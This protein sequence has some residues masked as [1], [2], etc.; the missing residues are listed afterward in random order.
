M[1]KKEDVRVCPRCKGKGHIKKSPYKKGANYEYKVKSKLELKGYKVYRSYASKGTFDLIATKKDKIIGVQVKRLTSKNPSY[2]T[3][4]DRESLNL[5]LER[6]DKPYILH[7][8]DMKIRGVTVKEFTGNI[9][10]I[11]TYKSKITTKWRKLISK[12]KWIPWKP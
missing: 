2:L 8:W 1:N 3:P 4:K 5:E 6:G 11:H 12:D 7:T 10:I 9:E